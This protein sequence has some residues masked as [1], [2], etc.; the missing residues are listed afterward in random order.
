MEP[1]LIAIKLKR[2]L[3][4]STRCVTELQSVS[5]PSTMTEYTVLRLST[6]VAIIADGSVGPRR[7]SEVRGMVGP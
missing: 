3:H 6:D 7:P 1:D 2:F 5:R 4:P